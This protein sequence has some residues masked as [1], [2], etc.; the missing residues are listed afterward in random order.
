MSLDSN[1]NI[2]MSF[3]ESELPNNFE[4]TEC[5]HCHHLIPEPNAQ[6]HE[7]SCNNRL[8]GL[9]PRR[10]ESNG[11]S[12]NG[13][14]VHQLGRNGDTASIEQSSHIDLSENDEPMDVSEG[15]H[16]ELEPRSSSSVAA[17]AAAVASPMNELAQAIPEGETWACPRCTLVN[18]NSSTHCDACYYT[19][20]QFCQREV[21]SPDVPRRE[22]LLIDLTH[23]PPPQLATSSSSSSNCD[24]NGHLNT[25]IS[26]TRQQGIILAGGALIGSVFGGA[27]ALLQGHRLDQGLLQGAATGAATGVILTEFLRPQPTPEPARLPINTTSV[28]TFAT[29]GPAGSSTTTAASI[30]SA[31]SAH[32]ST[33]FASP[34]VVRVVSLGPAARI[35]FFAN[36]SN[37]V[38]AQAQERLMRTMMSGFIVRDGTGLPSY[39]QLLEIF[40]DGMENRGAD[41]SLI[42]RLPVS[43]V[44]NPNLLPEDCRACSIC[45]SNYDKGEERKLL[46]CLHGFHKDC[47]DTWLS[48]SATCPVCKF[49][50][51]DH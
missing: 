30:P 11:N 36:G 3:H 37:G 20:D 44:E 49:E 48:R 39:E 24:N 31:T 15:D 5:P 41:A 45:L 33:T 26:T 25:P 7:V 22:P 12:I 29:N 17:V 14:G 35:T 27:S 51:K 2:S 19:R 9:D 18:T 28:V 8:R 10:M 21:W 38:E 34:P 47:I 43:S 23:S 1:N 42:N 16:L 6:L 13:Y 4:M 50:L 46:P 40:G 32:P